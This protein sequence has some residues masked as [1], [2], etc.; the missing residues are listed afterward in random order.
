MIDFLRRRAIHRLNHDGSV[1][2]GFYRTPNFNCTYQSTGST[3]MCAST[4]YGVLVRSGCEYS[5]WYSEPLSTC[6]VQVVLQFYC[7]HRCVGCCSTWYLVLWSTTCTLQLYPGKVRLL[8]RRQLC[9]RR[10]S[11]CTT[12]A[13]CPIQ[14]GMTKS[15]LG[16]NTVGKKTKTGNHGSRVSKIPQ[17]W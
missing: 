13:W 5:T 6:N 3:L 7:M 2:I 8:Q 1:R 4:S 16:W 9:T 12:V 15:D 10:S 17:P 11:D 14:P